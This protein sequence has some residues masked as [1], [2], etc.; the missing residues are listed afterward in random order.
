[1]SVRLI[2]MLIAAALVLGACREPAGTT[3]GGPS[4]AG[5]DVGVQTPPEQSPTADELAATEPID[6][7]VDLGPDGWDATYNQG[8]GVE[9][10]KRNWAEAYELSQEE[11][12]SEI[13]AAKE[14]DLRAAATEQWRHAPNGPDSGWSSLRLTIRQ[15]TSRRGIAA[16]GWSGRGTTPEG[17]RVPD[18]IEIGCSDAAEQSYSYDGAHYADC[19]VFVG[20]TTV[21]YLSSVAPDAAAATAG[22]TDGITEWL[23][24]VTAPSG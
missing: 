20:D 16:D 19:T 1:V 12:R 24:T 4:P 13:A 21:V 10:T 15:Y 5:R 3:D 7:M 11:A 2:V 18:G 23:E 17:I 8:A 14:A 6:L 9:V 22:A